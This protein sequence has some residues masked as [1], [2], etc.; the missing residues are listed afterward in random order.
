MSQLLL[1][2][3][4]RGSVMQSLQF[5]DKD[6]QD[7]PSIT[8]DALTRFCNAR[9]PTWVVKKL[10]HKHTQMESDAQMSLYPDRIGHVCVLFNFSKK[11]ESYPETKNSQ[12]IY[13][14]L[15]RPET[16]NKSECEFN[17]PFYNKVNGYV[18][19]PD[20]TVNHHLQNSR[21]PFHQQRL[22]HDFNMYHGYARKGDLLYRYPIDL[23]N[24]LEFLEG[25]AETLLCL[26]SPL[27][28]D[29]DLT[30]E[31]DCRT[32]VRRHQETPTMSYIVVD[33]VSLPP[34]SDTLKSYLKHH[35]PKCFNEAEELNQDTF[36]RMNYPIFF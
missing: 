23:G 22:V 30:L 27:N 6:W 10:L 9:V 19:T 14:L 32:V 31:G 17:K 15:P 33:D 21:A 4:L 3:P 18:W 2:H 7:K 29:R 36:K 16:G 5:L 35:A 1:N 12:I 8:E 25:I 34:W 13:G 20:V 24:D 26:T 28:K 11:N